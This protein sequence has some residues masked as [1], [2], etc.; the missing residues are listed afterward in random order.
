MSTIL[1]LIL[2]EEGKKIPHKFPIII[3]KMSCKS[4]SS[5]QI[6]SGYQ[7]FVKMTDVSGATSIPNHQNLIQSTNSNALSPYSKMEL[8]LLAN[9]LFNQTFT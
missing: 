4:I 6:V 2:L 5:N 7:L 8:Q 3:S 1:S 9:V